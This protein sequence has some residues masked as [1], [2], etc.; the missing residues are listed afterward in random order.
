VF[1]HG[2]S[3]GTIDLSQQGHAEPA[4]NRAGAALSAV[5]LVA[6]INLAYWRMLFRMYGWGRA[7]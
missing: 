5:R 4:T 7:A 3:T 6:D 2:E 1:R